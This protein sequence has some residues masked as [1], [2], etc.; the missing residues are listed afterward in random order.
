[1]LSDDNTITSGIGDIQNEESVTQTDQIDIFIRPQ[2]SINFSSVS[3]I[4]SNQVNN[5]ED[6][7]LDNSTSTC[8]GT[9]NVIENRH[10][11]TVVQS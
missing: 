6:N 5:I 3:R 7:K 4:D 9:K 10:F 11:T 8:T 1:M 2:L